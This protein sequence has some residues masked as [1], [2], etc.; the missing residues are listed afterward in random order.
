[1][2]LVK[3]PTCGAASS[4]M[5]AGTSTLTVTSSITGRGLG[6]GSQ[7]TGGQ[8]EVSNVAGAEAL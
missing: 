8:H 3:L 6:E 2:T 4:I 1:M 5:M 7:G